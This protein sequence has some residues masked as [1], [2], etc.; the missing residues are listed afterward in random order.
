MIHVWRES[1]AKRRVGHALGHTL[2]CAVVAWPLAYLA[3][4]LWWP[5]SLRQWIFGSDKEK[6]EQQVR[7][8]LEGKRNKPW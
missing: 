4:I 1:K 8:F 2:M 6:S 3:W 5:G 7:L